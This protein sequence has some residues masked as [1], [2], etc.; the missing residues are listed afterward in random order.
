MS[1]K[2]KEEPP[3]EKI[4][5][6]VGR[7]RIHPLPPEATKKS[8]AIEKSKKIIMGFKGKKNKKRKKTFSYF[9]KK[10]KKSFTKYPQHWTWAG[11]L[12]IVIALLAFAFLLVLKPLVLFKMDTDRHYKNEVN[13]A[14]EIRKAELD[15]DTE[16]TRLSDK[17]LKL[18]KENLD[19]LAII[20]VKNIDI[21]NLNKVLVIKDTEIY[22]MILVT[23][24]ILESIGSNNFYYESNGK[25]RFSGDIHNP[26]GIGGK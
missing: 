21:E 6:R 16:K 22:G 11:A 15:H 8:K 9:K 26:T 23:G 2:L 3:P 18:Q 19:L 12:I 5:R 24:R 1:E 4:T 13:V 10:F 20:E 14:Y 25:I 7:P 17:V